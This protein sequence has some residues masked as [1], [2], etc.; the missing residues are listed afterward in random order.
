MGQET[1]RLSL[2]WKIG[3]L[4]TGVMVVLGIFLLLAMYQLVRSC[5]EDQLA[6]RALAITTNFGDAAAGHI[7]GKNLL[8]LN[9]LTSKYTLHDGVAYAFIDDGRGQILAQTLGNFPAQIREGASAGGQREVRRRT[10]SL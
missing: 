5:I 2:K 1:R 3:G 10:L 8:G 4:Y 6:K 9:A 7:V